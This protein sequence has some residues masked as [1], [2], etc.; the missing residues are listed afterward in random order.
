MVSKAEHP[1]YKV[2]KQL[3]FQK[4]YSETLDCLI[5][6]DAIYHIFMG[7]TNKTKRELLSCG[8]CANIMFKNPIEKQA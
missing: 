4:S 2:C 8:V 5:T 3:D 7:E 6:D 1:L